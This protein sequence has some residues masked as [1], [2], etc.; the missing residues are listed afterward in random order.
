MPWALVAKL[1]FPSMSWRWLF[2]PY[3]VEGATVGNIN[4][5]NE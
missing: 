4:M 3:G 1:N 5:E 2:A